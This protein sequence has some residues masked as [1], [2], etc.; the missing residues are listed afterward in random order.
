MS[1]FWTGRPTIS[2][3]PDAKVTVQA[4]GLDSDNLFAVAT[5]AAKILRAYAHP[6]RAARKATASQ[7]P[8][9]QLLSAMFITDGEDLNE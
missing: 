5:E 6:G 1:E 4:E 3:A 2:F 8:G 7:K 9:I